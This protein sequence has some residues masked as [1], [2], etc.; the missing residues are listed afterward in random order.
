MLV[1]VPCPEISA[2]APAGFTTSAELNSGVF[3]NGT[4]GKRQQWTTDGAVQ[5]QPLFAPGIII[6]GGSPSNLLLVVTEHNTL[7]ALDTGDTWHI[8]FR[9]FSSGGDQPDLCPSPGV[10]SC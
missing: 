8:T 4:F 10:T 6:N 7:Y 3:G 1:S 9:F 5:A 2:L